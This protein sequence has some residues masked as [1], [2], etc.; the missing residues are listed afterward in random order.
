MQQH[1]NFIYTD[2]YRLANMLM[3]YCYQ[4][5]R[6]IVMQEEGTLVFHEEEAIDAILHY[7]D[8]MYRNNE[9]K[10]VDYILNSVILAYLSTTMLV[11]FLSAT[12]LA[13]NKLNNYAKFLFSVTLELKYRE[14]DRW[15][16][17]VKGF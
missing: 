16:N 8:D 4:A 10:I 17:L 12:A 6:N 7:T 2:E 3:T 1:A 13:K 15:E 9:F 14:P 11:A 5:N